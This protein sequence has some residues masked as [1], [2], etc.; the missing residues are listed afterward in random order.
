MKGKVLQSWGSRFED[1]P[2]VFQPLCPGLWIQ[3]INLLVPRV[4]NKV[5]FFPGQRTLRPSQCMLRLCGICPTWS[6]LFRNEMEEILILIALNWP[7]SMWYLNYW[8]TLHGPFCIIWTFSPKGRS[9]IYLGFMAVETQV[10]RKKGLLDFL[11][12][13][14]CG[15]HPVLPPVWPRSASDLEYHQRANTFPGYSVS[16]TIGLRFLILRHLCRL[17]HTSLPPIPW[18]LLAL[19]R[20]L[21]DLL[22]ILLFLTLL[23]R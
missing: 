15:T 18:D 10:L 4:D 6:V 7:K 20:L 14:L 9:T 19:L 17:S 12:S 1:H 16:L 13:L 2:V 5:G 22:G 11:Q 3:Y 21:L 23:A 8:E